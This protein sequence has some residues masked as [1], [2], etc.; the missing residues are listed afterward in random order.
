MQLIMHGAGRPWRPR[1]WRCRPT[2]V[3]QPGTLS[4]RPSRAVRGRAFGD[5]NDSPL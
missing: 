2:R 3:A 1:R 4:R 5:W